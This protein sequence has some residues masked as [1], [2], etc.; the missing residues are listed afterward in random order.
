MARHKLCAVHHAGAGISIYGPGLRDQHAENCVRRV[1]NICVPVW[2]IQKEM[3]L[4]RNRAL[5]AQRRM[6]SQQENTINF[7][8]QHQTQKR[9]VELIPRSRNQ[10]RLVMALRDSLQTIVVAS[11][12]AG[13]GKTWLAMQAAIRD[14]QHGACNRIVVTRP[15][16]GVDD[17]RHGFLPGDLNAKMEPWTRPLMDVLREHYRAADIAGMLADGVLE[18]SPLAYMRGRTFRDAWIVADEMQ[19]ATPSQLKMLLTRIGSNSRIV[20]TGDIEQTDRRGDQNGLGDLCRRLAYTTVPGIA[21]CEFGTR[22]IQ[23][24][25]II[26]AILELY[27]D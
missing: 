14:L 24:H 11:G 15:A 19:N 2:N 22:D 26:G 9:S 20:V 16:V 18:I 7:R 4:S 17:E 13:T 6:N 25:E 3:H 5:K 21:L 1:L 8:P 10:E 23:R 27:Q 12:P